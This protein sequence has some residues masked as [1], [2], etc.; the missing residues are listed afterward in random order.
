MVKPGSYTTAWNGC[1]QKG[2]RLAAGVYVCTLDGAGTRTTRGM[3]LTEQLISSVPDRAARLPG[4]PSV[5]VSGIG[6]RMAGCGFRAAGARQCSTGVSP[7][8]GPRNTSPEWRVSMVAGGQY[9]EQ[10]QCVRPRSGIRS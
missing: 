9:E 3:V 4:G 7:E 5:F 2:R 6:R 1:D 8:F 10:M